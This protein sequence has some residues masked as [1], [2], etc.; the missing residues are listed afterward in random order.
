MFFCG[1]IE[2][3]EITGSKKKLAFNSSKDKGIVVENFDNFSYDLLATTYISMFFTRGRHKIFFH[4]IK[5]DS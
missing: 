3:H 5:S 2:T 1:T 4:K